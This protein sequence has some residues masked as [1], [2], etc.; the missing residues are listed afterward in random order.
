M[1]SKFFLKAKGSQRRRI[2]T[3][4]EQLASRQGK[5]RCWVVTASSSTAEGVLA[6]RRKQT[7]P[8]KLTLIFCGIAFPL[9]GTSCCPPAHRCYRLCLLSE[10]STL[11]QSGWL[12]RP[13]QR[14]VTR[15]KRKKPCFPHFSSPLPFG[16]WCHYLDN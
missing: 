9:S 16:V 4:F 1:L 14:P 2:I 8:Q 12:W 7:S 15:P 10:R 11:P 13:L 3:Y 5:K 6:G